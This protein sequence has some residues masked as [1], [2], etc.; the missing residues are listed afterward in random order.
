[1]LEE[2]SLAG[3]RA[4]ITGGSTGLGR[5]MGLVLAEAGADVAISARR[6]ENLK[7]AE[8]EI[9]Q[10]GHKVVS[11]ATDVSDSAAVD[12]MVTE[13]T[14]ALGGIDI[15]INNAGRADD[16]PVAAL[17][18]QPGPET[19]TG[20]INP[21][22]G[23]PSMA[24]ETW[25]KTME[26][27]LNG[28]FYTCR[29]V[30]PQ[31]MERRYGKV[32]NIASTN[33][34]MAYPYAAPY[35]TSKAGLKMFT[36]VMAMEW[37]QFNINVNCILPGWFVTEMTRG[38]FDHPEWRKRIEEGLPLKRV[39]ANRDL[40]LLALYLASP[41]SDWMTGQAIALDGGETALHN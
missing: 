4:L 1:M 18:E 7:A 19:S 25:Q 30:A 23:A 6:L 8:E 31:M 13:A 17:P 22:E 16:G 35:Q 34:V 2:F 5:A 36:K 40:G 33:A 21:A 27:N 9:S 24:D 28:P 12:A 14:E 20:Y 41:A 37:A 10:H 3:K 11:I 29:A 39:T 32:I 15:L 38:V 26:T